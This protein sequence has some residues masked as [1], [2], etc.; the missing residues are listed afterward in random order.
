M[1]VEETPNKKEEKIGNHDNHHIHRNYQT[2]GRVEYQE[3]KERCANSTLRMNEVHVPYPNVS[4]L[5]EGG[6]GEK[7]E[8]K[9]TQ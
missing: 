2:K 5:R 7:K 9:K 1:I 6:R 8:K 3:S 4:L